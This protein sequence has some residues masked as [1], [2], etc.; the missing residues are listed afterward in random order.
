MHYEPRQPMLRLMQYLKV[1]KGQFLWASGASVVNKVFDLMPPLFVSWIIDTVSGNP[2]QWLY[3]LLGNAANIT[4]AGFLAALIVGIFFIESLFEWVYERAFK[5][6]AQ[7]VQHRLRIDAYAKMQ[8]REIA[9]FEEQRTGNLLS[10]L[11]ND[12]NE[13]ERFLNSSFNTI[14]QLL[15]LFV[16][17]SVALFQTSWQLALIGIVP[18]PLMVLVSAWYRKKIA[19]LYLDIRQSVGELNSRLE[20]N[21][22]GIAVIKSFTAEQLETARVEQAS[23]DYR[24]KNLAAIQYNTIFIP[25]VRMFIAMS[26]AGAM[27]LGAYWIMEGTNHI[28]IGALAFFAMM[29]QRLLWPITGL[30]N[31]FDSYERARAGARRI[32]GL[33]DTPAAIVSAPNAVQVE[34]VKGEVELKNVS[35]AYP[36]GVPVLNGINLHIPAGSMVG[37]AGMTGAGKT[38]LIKLLL[39]F[40]DVQNGSVLIDGT[41]VRRM[42]LH[43]LRQHIALVSQDVYLFHGTIYENIAYGNPNANPQ[44]VEQAAQQAQLHSFI[45]TLPQ[46][47]QTI[48]GERGIKLSGGQRQR[49]SIARAILKNAPI[50]L[51][52]E[53][54][55]AV[56]T[57]TERAIQENLYLLTKGKT[58]IVVA[59]RLSTIR[60]ANHI[61]ILD[62]GSIAEQGTHEALLAQNGIYADL[63]SVQIGETVGNLQ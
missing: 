7:A 2:P 26:L 24:Q 48:V 10:I 55:S 53:A 60:H 51:L 14:L 33:M 35:F 29:L 16:F 8:E 42:H 6:L 59:H 44:A 57:E 30:G 21:L 63:W 15:V 62:H 3:N 11:N 56:D 49:L 46:G 34:R 9:Y 41:D 39:R 5:R 27:F 52:D 4:V 28:T 13:L 43:Q 22:S 47:Y 61:L 18:I 36:N 20:N 1:Y 32:F 25:I 54:T 23:E 19:P 40:Y 58:A 45:T 31:V 12:I 38:T 17:A 37:L 50:L